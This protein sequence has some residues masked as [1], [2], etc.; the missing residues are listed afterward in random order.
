[1]FL[2]SIFDYQIKNIPY[3]KAN[4]CNIESTLNFSHFIALNFVIAIMRSR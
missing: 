2:D 3:H 4:K 1:M